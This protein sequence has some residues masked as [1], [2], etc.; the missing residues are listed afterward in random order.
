MK[1]LKIHFTLFISR[2]DEMVEGGGEEVRAEG[3]GLVQ[4]RFQRV[5]PPQH[6]LHP[7]HDP[8]GADVAF[9]EFLFVQFRHAEWPES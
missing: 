5:A 1:G 3:A 9:G 8:L 6:F 7:R 2:G 4:L